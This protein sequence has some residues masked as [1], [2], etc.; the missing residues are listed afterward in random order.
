MWE[1][2]VQSHL[3]FNKVPEKIWNKGSR[4]FGIKPGQIQKVPVKIAEAKPDKVSY[5]TVAQLMY[6]QYLASQNTSQRYIKLKYC[7]YWNYHPN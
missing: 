1:A 5:S 6:F 4:K 2:L 7:G 3:K